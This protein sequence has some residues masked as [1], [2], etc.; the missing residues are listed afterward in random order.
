[1]TNQSYAQSWINALSMPHEAKSAAFR[2]PPNFRFTRQDSKAAFFGEQN[3]KNINKIIHPPESNSSGIELLP[4]LVRFPQQHRFVHQLLSVIVIVIVIVM[5]VASF[6]PSFSLD[7]PFG[8]HLWSIFNRAFAAIVGYP[9]DSFE[10]TQDAAIPA[11]TLQ[12]CAAVLVTYYVVVLGGREF[13]RHRE[14]FQ[15][16]TAFIAHNFLLS[17]LSAVLLA[18]FLEQLIPT[19]ARHGILYSICDGNGG[20]TQR[21]VVLYYV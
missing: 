9:A 2:L 12:A 17:S 20:W 16:R 18:L 13:M 10:F 15:L 4:A 14:P 19:V 8:I 11:S 6:V 7:R 21:L 3:R 5:S 1:M